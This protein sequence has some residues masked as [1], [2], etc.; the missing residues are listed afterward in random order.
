[1]VHTPFELTYSAI[2]TTTPEHI[3]VGGGKVAPKSDT[4]LEKPEEPLTGQLVVI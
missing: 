3:L 1:M 2:R 4:F